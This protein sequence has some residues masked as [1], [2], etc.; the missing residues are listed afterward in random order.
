MVGAKCQDWIITA[1]SQC[2]CGHLVRNISCSAGLEVSYDFFILA[3]G[4]GGHPVD[5][6]KS[7]GGDVIG[8]FPSTSQ[9]ISPVPDPK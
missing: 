4:W 7:R 9:S 2:G 8:R 1:G 6:S 5:I 3:W